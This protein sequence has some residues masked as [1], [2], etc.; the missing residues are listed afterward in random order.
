MQILS[1]EMLDATGNRRSRFSYGEDILFRFQVQG[2]AGN[3]CIIGV[4][5]RDP[6]GHVI[7][8]LNNT[9]DSADIVLPDNL[10]TITVTMRKT[11]LNDSNYYVTIWLGDSMNLL[12]DRVGN[13]MVFT[14]DSAAQGYIRSQGVVRQPSAWD[15]IGENRPNNNRA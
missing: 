13:C 2:H 12:H 5:I 9:D 3:Q 14:I 15:V 7:L 1:L 11:I 6:Y 8:H 4:S 10:S